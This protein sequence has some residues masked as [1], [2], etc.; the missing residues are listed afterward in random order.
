M[1]SMGLEQIEYKLC[2]KMAVQEGEGRQ[3]G[4]LSSFYS[5]IQARTE[6]DLGKLTVST[7]RSAQNDAILGSMPH[8]LIVK[9]MITKNLYLAN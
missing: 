3:V 2:I 8:C 5:E 1:T 4:L 7:T 6:H 9:F